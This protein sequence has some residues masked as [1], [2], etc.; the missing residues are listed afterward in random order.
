M[1]AWTDLVLRY[2]PVGPKHSRQAKRQKYG[3]SMSTIKVTIPPEFDQALNELVTLSQAPSREAWL[4]NVVRNMLF[5]YQ[6]RKDFAPQQ[7]LRLQ[8]L[9]GLWPMP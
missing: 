9:N 1:D 2:E 5:D 4:A 8:Q 7:Q 3:G 6:F